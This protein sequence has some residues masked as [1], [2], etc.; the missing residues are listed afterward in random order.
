MDEHTV[1]GYQQSVCKLI[2]AKITANIYYKWQ[3]L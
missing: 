2:N 1:N 3:I